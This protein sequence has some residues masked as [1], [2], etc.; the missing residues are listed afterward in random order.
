MN[1]FYLFITILLFSS[2]RPN[3]ARIFEVQVESRIEGCV[4][5]H[6]VMVEA[7]NIS[8][9]REKAQRIVQ[10]KFKNQSYKCQRNQ[11]K[12]A[13]N[14][15]DWKGQRISYFYSVWNIINVSPANLYLHLQSKKV[16]QLRLGCT[17]SIFNG[18]GKGYEKKHPNF[19]YR[20]IN[21]DSVGNPH[22][23]S[24]NVTG[25]AAIFTFLHIAYSY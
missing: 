23:K 9:A 18:L 3:D 1:Y 10:Y 11:E 4:R 8:D 12:L 16:W 5:R 15:S 20:I 14:F 21:A 17:Q 13:L 7:K 22:P 25:R 24:Y 2:S 19:T 6:K